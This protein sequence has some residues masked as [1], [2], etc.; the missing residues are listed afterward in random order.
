MPTSPSNK[1]K[2]NRMNVRK[3]ELMKAL[4]REYYGELK[5]KPRGVYVN[6]QVLFMYRLCA[7]F[8]VSSI[9]GVVIAILRH[10]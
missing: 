5:R 7:L 3:I 4:Q 8:T 2:G 9:I 10:F 6:A 1:A